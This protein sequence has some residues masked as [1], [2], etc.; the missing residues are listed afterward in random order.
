M[1]IVSAAAWTAISV[2]RL[3]VDPSPEVVRRYRIQMGVNGKNTS[4]RLSFQQILARGHVLLMKARFSAIHALPI[5]IPLVFYGVLPIKATVAFR[6]TSWVFVVNISTATPTPVK[7]SLRCSVLV[8]GF[9]CKPN[10]VEADIFAALTVTGSDDI[11][12]GCLATMP[13]V[14]L[15]RCQPRE[16]GIMGIR[17]RR[18]LRIRPPSLSNCLTRLSKSGIFEFV[19]SS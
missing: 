3:D 8:K 9:L 7:F 19:E 4:I 10:A 14:A 1:L 2:A 12:L 18:I 11:V 5:R 17:F 13:R 15:R 6:N 16:V